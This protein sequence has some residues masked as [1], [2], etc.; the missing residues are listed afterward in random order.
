MLIYYGSIPNG[1]LKT[2]CLLQLNYHIKKSLAKMEKYLFKLKFG[3]MAFVLC[4]MS[5]TK[6]FAETKTMTIAFGSGNGCDTKINA[7]SV[8]YTDKLGNEWAITTDGTT[9]FT[10]NS[11]YSQVGSGNKPAKSVTFTMTLPST[12][13]I[14]SFS[15][16][17]GG[18]NGTAGDVSITVDGNE[19]AKGSLNATN[20]VNVEMTKAVN[21]KTLAITVKNIKKGVKV[22][23]LSY[24]YDDATSSGEQVALLGLSVTGTPDEFW[25]GSKFNTNGMSVFVNFSDGTTDDV[26]SDADFAAPDMTTAGE[27]DV[28]VSWGNN[29]TASYKI[30][31]KTIANTPETAY[32]TAKAR[33]MIDAGNDLSTK[34]YVK[35]T[36]SKVDK[37]DASKG[38]ITYWL[39]DNAFEIYQGKNQ[40][41]AKF[42]SIENVS[43]GADVVVYGKLALYGK[44]TYEFAAGSELYSYNAAGGNEEPEPE[45][46]P[47]VKTLTS[48]AVT[49]TPEEFWIGDQFNTNGMTVTAYYSDESSEDVTRNVKWSTPDM[50]TAGEKEVS[51]ICGSC[52]ATY[53]ILVKTIANTPETAY[54]TAKAKEL[55]DAGKDLN[56]KVYVKGTVS[57]VEKYDVNKGYITYW[58]D[59]NAFE[60]F[61][62]YKLDGAK[63]EAKEDVGVGADVVVYGK[64]TLYN[65]STYE[66]ASGN[67]LYS[68]DGTNVVEESVAPSFTSQPAT[69][70]TYSK[71]AKATNLTVSATGTPAPT[72]QWFRNIINST[73]DATLIEGATGNSYLPSTETTGVTYYYCV[74]TN[75]AGSVASNFSKITVRDKSTITTGDYLT[76]LTAGDVD[77]YTVESNSDAPVTVESKNEKV[78]TV[79]IEG[80]VVTV[81]ALGAGTAQIVFKTAATDHYETG[82]KTYTVNVS[83]ALVPADL[84]FT[85]V[86][87]RS[88]VENAENMMQSGLGTDYSAD[89]KLKFDGTGDYMVIA[90]KDEPSTISFAIKGNGFTNGTFEVLESAD[91]K[92]YTVVKSFSSYGDAA[93]ETASLKSASRFV[94][95]L[96]TKKEAGNVGIGK[97]TIYGK[98]VIVTV[99]TVG[100]EDGAAAW[101]A[102]TYTRS[103][104]TGKISTI[105]LPYDAVVEGA[106]VYALEGKTVKNGSVSSLDFMLVG[107]TADKSNT[108]EAGVPYVYRATADVQTFTKTG[109]KAGKVA[110][111]AGTEGFTGTY[112]SFMLPVGGYFLYNKPEDKQEFSKAA[113]SGDGYSYVNIGAFK[114]YVS[115][116]DDICETAAE[117]VYEASRRLV[118]GTE[119]DEST[120][121]VTLDT[122]DVKK[123]DGKYVENGRLVIVKNGVK[124][125]ANG[126]RMF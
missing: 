35:G 98:D 109:D 107:E 56:T 116:M 75:K 61:Q 114:C 42:T 37:Y 7:K 57:K 50:I 113:D 77:T 125:N 76:A 89:T 90:F 80:N 78:A 103:V 15:A 69:S 67:E 84:D 34:V 118:I 20:D 110:P 36:V 33:E 29:L 82:S 38:Y 79:S 1:V 86:G 21:G 85:F 26:T 124:Y 58:L 122:D 3:L 12:K 100:A 48:I 83:A 65:N 115:S 111:K 47:V 123:A 87:G 112:K 51:V 64:L 106:V 71:G 105:C 119:Y 32:T 6:A 108:V 17:F 121:I 91:N 102:D 126:Q 41:G 40:N 46:E 92:T 62:G 9:S 70:K 96:Y 19:V 52:D 13:N 104:A 27:K 97:V 54:T 18:F 81:T 60:I 120:G 74:A 44:T 72:L 95:F 28:T 4:L 45:P 66:F 68:Y 25:V 8:S 55:I 31:V 23:N 59:N 101:T 117:V 24:S 22:Y 30:V 94:K 73:E 11:A 14:K 88:N 2:R 93:T 16:N 39:D 10:Q 5:M 43:V 99:P 53:K 63:F 49:G